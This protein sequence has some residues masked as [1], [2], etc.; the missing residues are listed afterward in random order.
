MTKRSLDKDIRKGVRLEVATHDLSRK[1]APAGLAGL[2]F[3]LQW[4]AVG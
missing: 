4:V 2:F 1:F 3:A